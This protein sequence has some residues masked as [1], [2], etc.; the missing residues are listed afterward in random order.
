MRPGMLDR[1]G[2]RGCD[3]IPSTMERDAAEPEQQESDNEAPKIQLASIT[4]RVLRV[5]AAPRPSHS[6]QQQC[7]VA[8]IDD[9]VDRLRHHG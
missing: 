8:G 6:V 1:P 7:L 9:T 5:G 3:S 2:M 4:K